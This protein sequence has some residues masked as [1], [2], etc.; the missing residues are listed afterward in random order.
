[1][2]AAT[3]N[4]NFKFK[5]INSPFPVTQKLRDREASS[6]GIFIV[7]IIGIGFALIPASIIS[8]IVSEREKNLKHMQIISGM[9]LA[10]YWISNYIFDI[11]KTL[12]VMVVAIGLLYA[13]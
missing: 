10:A 4:P 12:I 5:V 13:Y 11:L 8:A 2:K 3:G 6:N 9:S 1:M 7:F